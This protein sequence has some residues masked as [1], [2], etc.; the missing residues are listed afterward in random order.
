MTE[1]DLALSELMLGY[2]TNFA[3]YGDPNGGGLPLWEAGRPTFHQVMR[4]DDGQ[5]RMS[6]VSTLALRLSAIAGAFKKIR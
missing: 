1:K 4:F 5:P 6:K 3:K 2:L